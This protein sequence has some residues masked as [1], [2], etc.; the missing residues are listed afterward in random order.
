MDLE[1]MMVKMG[2]K[3]IMVVWEV[4]G[5]QKVEVRMRSRAVLRSRAYMRSRAVR[6]SI[7]IMRRRAV[8]RRR[9][10]MRS[11]VGKKFS[12]GLSVRVSVGFEMIAFLDKLQLD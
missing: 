7:V 12:F 1:K 5:I 4:A 10:E 9:A 2:W 11:R 6:R 3:N 8:R